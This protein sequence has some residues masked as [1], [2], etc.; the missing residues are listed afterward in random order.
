MIFDMVK[1]ACGGHIMDCRMG[2]EEYNI[3]TVNLMDENEVKEWKKSFDIVSADLPCGA[4]SICYTNLSV[5][6]EVCN[7]I[8]KLN[9]DE[10]YPKRLIR[11]MKSYRIINN[12]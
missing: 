5:A 9:N 3:Q 1:D 12:Q 8:K 11:H 10:N 2:G 6:A 7:I 4:K